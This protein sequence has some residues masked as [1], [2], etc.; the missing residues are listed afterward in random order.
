MDPLTQ[1]LFMAASQGSPM[2][3]VYD[4]T[5]SSGTTV[6]LP[7]RGSAKVTIVWGDGNQTVL[8]TNAATYTQHT[9]ASEGEYTVKVYGRMTDFG[10]NVS[11][12]GFDKL[13]KVLSFGQLGLVSLFNAF[14]Q[15]TNLTEI[16]S[17]LPRSVQDLSNAFSFLANFNVDIS[18]W[19]TSNVTDMEN[20]FLGATS[21]N[22]DIGSWNTSSVTSM[23]GMF[24]AA[25]SFNQDIGGWD[26]S[27][28]T[29]MEFMFNGATSFNQ[30]IGSWNT[31]SVTNMGRMFAGASAFNQYIGDWDV[32]NVENMGAMFEG[33]TVFNQDIS[34]WDMSSVVTGF[35][36]PSGAD[37]MFE[38]ATAFNQDLSSIV[39]GLTSQPSDFSLNGNATFSNNANGLKP[40]LVD[41]VTQ[42]NT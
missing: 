12:P 20:L 2:E 1:R 41:G 26:T 3:L 23:S 35:F 36:T 16:T 9:Y 5:L 40:F 7:T 38:D 8:N 19:D 4:T 13:T 27:N 32:S 22:Q 30:D 17:V 10:G 18:G 31:S 15:A 42:I 34:G 39:T 25:S 37:R 29:D 6:G 21:F 33:A 14:S 24:S 28:T 11:R